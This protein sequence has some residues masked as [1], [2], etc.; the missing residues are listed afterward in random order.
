MASLAMTLIKQK[1]ISNKVNKSQC[2][3]MLHL[4]YRYTV[5]TAAD[6]LNLRTDMTVCFKKGENLSVFSV[7]D[8]GCI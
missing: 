5:F 1:L 2:D 6:Y 8:Q 3:W 4:Y 7:Y